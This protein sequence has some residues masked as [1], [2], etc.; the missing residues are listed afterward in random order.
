MISESRFVNCT[1]ADSKLSV[2]RSGSMMAIPGYP[3][4]FRTLSLPYPQIGFGTGPVNGSEVAEVS[5]F[6]FTSELVRLVSCCSKRAAAPATWGEDMLVPLNMSYPPGTDDIT[7]PPRPLMSGF[8]IPSR[9]GPMPLK[10][11]ISSTDPDPDLL[12]YDATV[13]AESAPAGI[14]NV[15]D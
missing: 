3:A 10:E 7:M 15:M 1:N 14:P 9:R 2:S 6:C 11:E 13:I 12:L 4:A 8:R 5:S